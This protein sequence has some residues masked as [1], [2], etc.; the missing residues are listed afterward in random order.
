MGYAQGTLLNEE[1]TEFINNVWIYFEEQIE[2]VLP[3]MPKWIAD[4][5]ADIGLDLALDA[6]YE[7]TK[8]YTSPDVYEEIKGMSD[9]SGVDYNT[10]VRVH[11]IAGLTQGKCSMFGAWGPALDPSSSTEL[12][13]LRA[14]DWDMDGPFRNHPGVTVYH[15][16]EGFAYA[17]IG[18]TGFVGSL[19]GVSENKLGI[20]EIGVTYPDDSFGSESRIGTPFIFILKDI[21]HKD[22]TLD[23]ATSRLA[24]ARR[25]CDL[26]L[27]VGDGK[28]KE[29][30][31]YQY[32]YSQLHEF[33]DL[34]MRPNNSTWH[35][36][37]PGLV[38]WGMDWLC[39]AYNYVLSEQLKQHYGKITPEVA[40]KYITSV[41]M[42]GDN[43]LSFY[44]L[45]NQIFYVS[46][47]APHNVGGNPAAYARQF[48]VFDAE[49]LFAEEKPKLL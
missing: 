48:T 41:E 5:I 34:N 35:P 8:Y 32:S 4:W 18:M 17:N 23:D 1:I 45:T 11:M 39:P 46:F 9:A 21:L 25:T 31:G 30:R 24:S 49:Q 14:L 33:N 15:P 36:K 27:G 13:Q 7:M 42:S 16:D 37:M 28:M 6:T 26:I 29:F 12:L 10:A 44:D 43:H 22:Y 19:T 3:T 47:A 40:I 2:E 38:Y 20:S